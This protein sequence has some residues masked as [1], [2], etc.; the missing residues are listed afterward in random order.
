MTVRLAS[1]AETDSIRVNCLAP[2]WI[3]TEHVREY[4]TL[5][6]PPTV[7]HAVCLRGSSP[8]IKSRMLLSGFLKTG[9]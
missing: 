5:S 1:S 7:L 2:G 6:R 8:F 3:G 4:W 9:L